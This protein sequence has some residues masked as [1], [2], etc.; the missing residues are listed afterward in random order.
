MTSSQNVISSNEIKDTR[1][2]TN[3][4]KGI[5]I[6]MVILTHSHQMFNLPNVLRYIPRFGQMGCQIFFVL[7][8]F[9]L[10]H[11]FAK[12]TPTWLSHMKNR[13]SKLAVGFWLAIVV[14]AVY[15][16][17]CFLF[18]DQYSSLLKAI[19]IPGI[20][21]NAL[22]LNGLVP[23]DG[24]NNTI[25]R[26]GWYIGTTVILYALFPLLYRFYYS[27][28]Y[29]KW[30][31]YRFII[32][33]LIILFLSSC[34]VVFSG[35]ISSHFL[36]KNNSFVYFSFVNQISPFTLGIVLYDISNRF[37]NKSKFAYI[38]S[39][40]FLIAS[41]V[42]FF[43]N[44]K[45]SFVFCQTLIA[46]AFTL[47]FWQIYNNAKIFNS[48]SNSSNWVIR[49]ICNFG[50]LSFPIYLFHSFITYEFSILCLK[51]LN[52]IYD[53]EVLWY[54]LL[55]PAIICLSY[56]IGFIF[57]KVIIYIS[58]ATKMGSNGR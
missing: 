24:I 33:P 48:I 56:L 27:K 15:R 36:C 52:S 55:L 6:F 20:I 18:L 47:F 41:I 57:N 8:A 54:L 19:N 25:V 28:K 29:T 4:F 22:F 46:L 58:N 37:N 53:N 50:K 14:F 31:K 51:I 38:A 44:Y 16:I 17:F 9:G 7:S 34:A 21:V 10:C 11:V 1:T 30:E 26:G 35:I 13:L 32:F 5:A 43:G 3:F 12:K 49:I 23:F 2:L 45:Y 40:T 42:L 39:L